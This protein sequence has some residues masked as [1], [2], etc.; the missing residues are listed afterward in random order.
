[1][2]TVDSIGFAS[3]TGEGKGAIDVF[4]LVGCVVLRWRSLVRVGFG[5][6]VEFSFGCLCNINMEIP[7]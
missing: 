3:A 4:G 1:M 7:N 6:K 2:M 5:S